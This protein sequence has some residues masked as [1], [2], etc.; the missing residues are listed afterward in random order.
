MSEPY[1]NDPDVRVYVGHAVD[2]LAG[3]PDESVHCILTSPPFY[4]L[5]D[6]GTGEWEGGDPACDHLMRAAG[7]P[8]TGTSTFKATESEARDR[9]EFPT[10]CGKC[11][12]RRLDRQ[13]GLEETPEEWADSLVAVFREARRV[14]RRDGTLWVE[15]GDSYA[16]KPRGTDEGWETSRVSN[17]GRLQKTQ[18]ASMQGNG[19]HR[20]KA[21]GIKEKD[22]ILAPMLLA[23][24]LRAD[25]WVLR[26][27]YPW[28]KPDAMP[29]SADDR[30]TTDFSYLFHFARSNRP[31]F[32]THRDG[33]GAR[34]RPQPDYRWINRKTRDERDTPPAEGEAR[35]W[36]RINLW[37]GHDYFF[38]RDAI[39]EPF[40]ESDGGR[41][42][43]A[44]RGD[45]RYTRSDF[46]AYAGDPRNARYSG[47]G[48]VA[49][50]EPL[51][52]A[53]PTLDG[54]QPAPEARGPDGR[55][56]L[57]V[58]AQ[59]NSHQHRSGSRWPAPEGRSPRSVWRIT[60]EATSFGL[61]PACRHFWDERAPA[62]H[63]GVDVVAHFAT[64]P[65]ELVRRVLACATSEAGVCGEC[66]APAVRLVQAAGG[67]IGEN[68]NERRDHGRDVARGAQMSADAKG[69]GDYRL[70]QLGWGRSCRCKA[71]FVPAVALD[72]FVGSGTTA[73]QARAMGRHCVGVELNP[74]FAEIAW[75]RL[76]Q[77]SL[78]ALPSG[79]P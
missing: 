58:E 43:A 5:R 51:D 2:V 25:G 60:T 52:D 10:T 67:A 17:P 1:V 46:K 69:R 56:V 42:R 3:L 61:C 39:R 73:R 63:C 18:R 66:G 36:R 38:D 20:A 7:G 62:K 21:S 37:K 16:S 34:R 28:W 44:R 40:S 77:Q 55:R 74:D 68:F 79:E 45:D 47:L 75:H 15:C 11:G 49:G 23:T 19:R 53:Q 72:P 32:W 12:A 35:E 6:Y 13:I 31:T 22:L 64:W 76:A 48:G 33:R 65:H 50:P 54:S 9:A 71:P 59:H 26:G 30:C 41:Q 8:R 4:G 24:T 70:E 57:H 29:E 27:V 78:L 14:L